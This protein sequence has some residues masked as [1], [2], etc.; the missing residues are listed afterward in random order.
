MA[1][2]ILS[3]EA[4]EDLQNIWSFIAADNPKAADHV[5]NELFNAFEE[6]A[7]WPGKGHTR[8]DLTD[9]DVLFW[10][11]RSYLVVY[12]LRKPKLQIVSHPPRGTGY[13]LNNRLMIVPE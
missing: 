5:E 7:R 10:P 12:R 2:Y 4:C 9:R 8:R 11:V 6:L 1:D 13:S 3:P